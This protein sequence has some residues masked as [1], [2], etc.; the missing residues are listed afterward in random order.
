MSWLGTSSPGKEGRRKEREKERRKE[1]RKEG[2]KHILVIF[3]IDALVRLLGFHNHPASSLDTI[4][5][6]DE[7][8][9]GGLEGCLFVLVVG[10]VVVAEGGFG[11]FAFAVFG[12]GWGGCLGFGGGGGLFGFGF[13]FGFAG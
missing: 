4:F 10:V 7:I 5:I 12:G 11:G 9:G 3:K 2:K 13:R 6:L 8:G 1:R